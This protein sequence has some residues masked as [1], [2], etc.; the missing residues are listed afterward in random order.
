MTERRDYDQKAEKTKDGELVSSFM[1]SPE[2]AAKEFEES[3]LLYHQ[4]TGR[5]QPPKRDVIMY[6][7]IQ[8]F[9]PGEVSPE[10]ANRIG[11]EL[12]MKFTG[13]Q[14]QFVVATH[15]DKKHIHTHIEFNSTNINCD[16]K[17]K[18]VKNSYLV[19]RRLN[20]DLC[21]AHGLSVIEDPKPSAKKQKEIAAA[22][23]GTSHKEQLRQ[24]IDRVIPDCRSY[25]DFL[26]RMRAEGYEVKEGKLLSFRAPGWDRFTRS[27]KLGADYTKEALRE[28]STTRRGYS[29]AAKK[30]VQRTGR[31]I[32]LLIDIQ[33]KMAAG[34]GAGYERWAK[35]FNL[36]EAAKTLNFLIENDLT[37]YDELAARAGQ[38]G[39]RFD[40]VSRR[41]KQLEARMAEAAQL[42]THIINYSKTREVYAA[43]KKSRHKKEFLA[44]HG[45]EIAQHEAA[46][47][48]FDALGGKPI[49]KVAQ[50][51]EQYAALLAEK[52]EEYAEY[53][54]LRQDMI[55]YR[56]A[57]Q[58]V[59]K[60]LGLVPED[61]E[62]NREQKPER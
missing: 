45:A 36:K 13:G 8:S 55:A 39:A 53:K 32:N 17:F 47:K 41:I 15:V 3:K 61:Q 58:N 49:P 5:K 1:C 34:K 11:Y 31:K 38:A 6:R 25:D 42:K 26:D 50:L 57:K 60:I 46:K 59:D 27:Y 20:D 16:G 12:A 62:Q 2:T 44:E 30:P 24:T 52:Q 51:S 14:H 18:N 43:Y 7:V 40:D 10:E 48:A 33:A 23:Y 4:L 28:R 35:V 21:R 54:V 19:L 56:T 37:D 29:A 22:K 9:K